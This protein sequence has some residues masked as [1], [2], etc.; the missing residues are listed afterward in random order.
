MP[1]LTIYSQTVEWHVLQKKQHK[2]SVEDISNTIQYNWERQKEKSVVQYSRPRNTQSAFTT[3]TT[4]DGKE[5]SKAK[6]T[7]A[8]KKKLKKCLCDHNKPDTSVGQTADQGRSKRRD[9]KDENFPCLAC[10]GSKHYFNRCYLIWGKEKDWI[11]EESQKLFR[12]NMKHSVFWQRVEDQR[13]KKKE[14]ESKKQENNIAWKCTDRGKAKVKE[15]SKKVVSA[16]PTGE[17]GHTFAY[18]DNYSLLDSAASV[19][20][21]QNKARFTNLRQ[22]SQKTSLLCG[23]NI[24]KIYG[25]GNISLPLRVENQISLLVLKNIA[26]AP[27]F[28][29]NL[30]SLSCLEDQGLIWNHMSGE[31]SNNAAQ[32]IGYT[33]WNRNNY[34]IDNSDLVTSMSLALINLTMIS[35]CS[36]VYGPKW[37]KSTRH[38]HNLNEIAN[39]FTHI[40]KERLGKYSC[41]MSQK[42]HQILVTLYVQSAP[43][44][45]NSRTF[46]K[47]YCSLHEFS[48]QSDWRPAN[49][50]L[51]TWHRQMEYIGPLDLYKLGKECLEVKLKGKSM[52]Q[53]PHCALSK[54]IQQISW[55]PLA[56]KSRKLFHQVFVD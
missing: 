18:P 5:A 29:L 1:S 38:S 46:N 9:N 3:D 42:A 35:C 7:T 43:N 4:F 30:V 21:F 50:S 10:S 51:N 31:I 37:K 12:E 55:Q 19:Y 32:V 33:T 53:Y 44:I 17:S 52:Y 2:Y 15:K 56:N 8:D 26:F 16:F 6:D 22:T 25:Q 23:Q 28:P 41:Q 45:N 40:H 34:E 39:F 49:V 27:N 24:V 36:Y 47:E 14:N 13:K 11:S 48:I 20:I 54:I